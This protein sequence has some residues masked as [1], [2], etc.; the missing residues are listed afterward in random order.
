MERE[1]WRIQKV[2]VARL[3]LLM[4]PS[5]EQAMGLGGHFQELEFT[6]MRRDYAVNRAH[7]VLGTHNQTRSQRLRDNEELKKDIAELQ[8]RINEAA[9]EARTISV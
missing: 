8:K 4:I 9:N 6:V 2:R 1:L 5:L 3:V 7:T